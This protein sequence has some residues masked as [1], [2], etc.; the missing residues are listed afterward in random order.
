MISVVAVTSVTKLTSIDR[1]LHA[2]AT[3]SFEAPMKMMFPSARTGRPKACSSV[4]LPIVARRLQ[5]AGEVDVDAGRQRQHEDQKPNRRQGPAQQRPAAEGQ[6]QPPRS[7]RI[8]AF[9]AQDS[10]RSKHQYRAART[11]ATTTQP[12]S[13]G[14]SV[15][16][17][18]FVLTLPEDHQGDRDDQKPMRIVWLV[19]PLLAQLIEIRRVRSRQRGDDDTRGEERRCRFV[20]PVQTGL[21]GLGRDTHDSFPLLP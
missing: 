10:F 3:S 13:M 20:A 12:S 8:E 16:E 6:G 2:W 7:G 18:Q 1:P 17:V 4:V 21:A 5:R 9:S 19:E 11:A 15:G 14:R